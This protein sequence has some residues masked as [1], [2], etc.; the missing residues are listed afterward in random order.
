MTLLLELSADESFVLKGL[1]RVHR[2]YVNKKSHI[3][4]PKH[5]NPTLVITINNYQTVLLLSI[6]AESESSGF[7]LVCSML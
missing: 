7:Q 2:C 1:R 4:L 3:Y 5:P 6:S